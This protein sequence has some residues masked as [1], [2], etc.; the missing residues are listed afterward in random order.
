MLLGWQNFQHVLCGSGNVLQKWEK[1]VL[2]LSQS[3]FVLS[4]KDQDAQL[5]ILFLGQGYDGGRVVMRECCL[6]SLWC[7]G[8]ENSSMFCVAVEMFCKSG[9]KGCYYEHNPILC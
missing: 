7:W 1:K 2:L 6:Q 8:D 9:I 5:T 4:P 3:N